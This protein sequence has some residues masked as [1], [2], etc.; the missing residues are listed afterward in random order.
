MMLQSRNGQEIDV[1]ASDIKIRHIYAIQLLAFTETWNIKTHFW[2][3]KWKILHKISISQKP[4]FLE[5][6][7]AG[8]L[9]IYTEMHLET[10]KIWFGYDIILIKS[11]G[12]GAIFPTSSKECAEEDGLHK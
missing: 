4:F 7:L 3:K 1:P 11:F 9:N 6:I 5:N 2:K 8:A 12:K 10:L